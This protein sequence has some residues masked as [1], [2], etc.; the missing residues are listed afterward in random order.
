M[1]VIVPAVANNDYS[2]H[3]LVPWALWVITAITIGRSLAHI[4]KHDGG[5]QSIASIPLDTV[6]VLHVYVPYTVSHPL[7]SY[8]L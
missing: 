6:N 5:G 4:F 7:I 2:G 8:I 1:D 3:P